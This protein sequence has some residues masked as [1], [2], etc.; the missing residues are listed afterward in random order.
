[1]FKVRNIM[2]NTHRTGLARAAPDD[3]VPTESIASLGVRR[4]P[5]ARIILV[6]A[7]GIRLGR[8][9]FGTTKTTTVSA[10][11][12]SVACVFADSNR[13]EYTGQ[14]R[15]GT[16]TKAKTGSRRSLEIDV[17]AESVS[18][19]AKAGNTQ[20][21]GGRRQGTKSH[22]NVPRHGAAAAASPDGRRATN[23]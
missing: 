6:A 2:A 1:M 18:V 22:E 15:Q 16:D 8:A 7:T 4:G 5:R 14:M 19:L 9:P 13:M 12:S 23:R 20:V 21:L 17:D 3:D 10:A 11:G